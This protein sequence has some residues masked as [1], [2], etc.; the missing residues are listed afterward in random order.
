MPLADSA[1]CLRLPHLM[2]LIPPANSWPGTANA[3]GIT[4]IHHS[5]VLIR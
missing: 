5:M 2:E 4:G 1:R 3:T